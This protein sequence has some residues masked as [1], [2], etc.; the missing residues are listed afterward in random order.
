MQQADC[1]FQRRSTENSRVPG[2]YK[3]EHFHGYPK[4]TYT[5]TGN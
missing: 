4:Q 2:R 3:M 1:L 5:C